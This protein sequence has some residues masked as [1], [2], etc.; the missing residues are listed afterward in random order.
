VEFVNIEFR[1]PNNVSKYRANTIF[2]KEPA[3]IAW[4]DSMPRGSVFF[5][6]GA[7]IGIYSIYAAS[8]GLD[9]VAV[10]PIPASFAALCES[11]VLN[12]LEVQVTPVCMA[13]G[14]KSG[15]V[16][17]G[18]NI[19]GAASDKASGLWSPV[20]SLDTLVDHLGYAPTHIKIDTD[21]FDF[22][23]LWGAWKTLKQAASV[24]VEVDLRRDDATTIRDLMKSSGFRQTG[25][26]VSPLT[27]Q[28][29]IG[30]DHWHKEN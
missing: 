24:I 21:G 3:T 25:R 9:V 4:I 2:T 1:T 17:L 10:E 12:K 28:S 30:M 27:P 15:T 13:L 23:V 22:D 6:I 11:V 8:Q 5:D 26:F 18:K 7:N 14:K 19:A 29:P 20:M 16:R